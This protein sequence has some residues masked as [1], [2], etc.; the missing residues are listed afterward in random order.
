M[1]AGTYAVKPS[2]QMTA[3]SFKPKKRQK[4]AAELEPEA[5][6]L[7][8]GPEPA[9]ASAAAPPSTAPAASAD[10]SSPADPGPDHEPDQLTPPEKPASAVPSWEAGTTPESLPA[11]EAGATGLPLLEAQ[12]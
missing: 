7:P 5:T 11:A 9:S 2:V 12:V 4:P 8:L 3:M 1:P 10:E 6:E